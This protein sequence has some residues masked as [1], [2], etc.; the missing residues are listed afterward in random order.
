M[1]GLLDFLEKNK[2][3]IGLTSFVI[4]I[5]IVM[6]SVYIAKYIIEKADRDIDRIEERVTNYGYSIQSI[7]TKINSVERRLSRLERNPFESEDE[8]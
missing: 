4:S 6:S 3:I 8:E 2:A 7:N 1:N 5:S